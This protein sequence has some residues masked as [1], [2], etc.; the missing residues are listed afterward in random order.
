M[1]LPC[2]TI[3][4]GGKDTVMQ[5][6]AIRGMSWGDFSLCRGEA[7]GGTGRGIPPVTKRRDGRWIPPF[8]I[9]GLYGVCR[10]LVIGCIACR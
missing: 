3:Q 9:G 10:F 1:H 4:S 7:T 6:P 2:K 5:S 8:G